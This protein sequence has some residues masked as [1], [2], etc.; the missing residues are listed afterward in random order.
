[1]PLLLVSVRMASYVEYFQRNKLSK[2]VKFT[3]NVCLA[4]QRYILGQIFILLKFVSPKLLNTPR[5]HFQKI[6]SFP[7][8][9]NLW[10]QLICSYFYITGRNAKNLQTKTLQKRMTQ[11]PE[12]QRLK[13][14]FPVANTCPSFDFFV[15]LLLPLLQRNGITSLYFSVRFPL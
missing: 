1:M 13:H 2:T 5:S 11:F 10:T 6:L 3:K 15:F 4:T 7:S 9:V 8:S 14:V 12:R